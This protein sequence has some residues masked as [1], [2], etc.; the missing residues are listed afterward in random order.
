MVG[1]LSKPERDVLAETIRQRDK[2]GDGLTRDE[3][4][5]IALK[6]FKDNK[7]KRPEDLHAYIKRLEPDPFRFL[8]INFCV[9]H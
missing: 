9:E 5:K 3:L 2:T 7:R 1:G 8:C 4:K 6:F